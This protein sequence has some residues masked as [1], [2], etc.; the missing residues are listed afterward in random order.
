MGDQFYTVKSGDTLFEI[1]KMY[2]VPVDVITRANRLSDPNTIFVGQVLRI[3]Q[4]SR[5]LWYMVR[6]GD[7]L[8]TIAKRFFTTVDNIVALN[9]LANPD[10]IYP[11]D[12][13]RIR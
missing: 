12:R 1:A 10:V 5:P 6:Y 4:S 9:S 11:G 7:T 13:I 8:Y 3:P 2:Q